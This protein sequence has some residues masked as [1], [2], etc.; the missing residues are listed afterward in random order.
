[1]LTHVNSGRR[2]S[3]DAAVE[4]LRERGT[5]GVTMRAVAERA[6]ITATAIY[7]HFADKEALLAEALKEAAAVF[8]DRML[9]AVGAPTAV[10]RLEEALGAS[11]AF[12]IDQP[13]LYDAL[14]VDPPRLSAGPPGARGFGRRTIFQLLVD[15]VAE[16]MREGTL[17]DDDATSVALTLAAHAQGL[18]LLHR[19]GRFGSD[20]Q[21]AEFWRTSFARVL[22]GL[23]E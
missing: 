13:R 3:L 12:A 16:C 23:R 14:F 6:G 7:R 2:R 15:R 18:V 17:R 1:V 21:F 19:R 10:E 11:R 5:A 22:T 4:V 9:D 20:A 8:R